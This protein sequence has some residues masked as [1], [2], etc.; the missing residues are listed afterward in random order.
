MS[1][2]FRVATF[3]TSCPWLSFI[4]YN[5]LCMYGSRACIWCNDVK[6]TTLPTV[7]RRSPSSASTLLIGI[8]IANE[9]RRRQW[10]VYHGVGY[11]AATSMTSLTLS[12]DRQVIQWNNLCHKYHI[13]TRIKTPARLCF[14]YV[15]SVC[16]CLDLLVSSSSWCLGGAA[17]C[18]CG[19]P[20]TFLLLFFPLVSLITLINIRITPLIDSN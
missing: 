9:S 8:E 2:T 17:V 20:W 12:H 7:S 13:T 4:H 5:H 3:G 16:A 14:S 1:V 19:T 6:R 10:W 15:C 18:D 11:S